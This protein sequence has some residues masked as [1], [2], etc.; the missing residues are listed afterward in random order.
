MLC[1]YHA[2]IHISA[3]TCSTSTYFP[4]THGNKC[5]KPSWLCD[6]GRDCSDGSDEIKANCNGGAA[7]GMISY[8]QLFCCR[9]VNGILSIHA[10]VYVKV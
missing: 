4:C 8:T 3:K 10:H 1:I 5:I 6:G 7:N 9:G 2:F